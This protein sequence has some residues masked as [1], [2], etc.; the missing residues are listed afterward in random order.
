MIFHCVPFF[1]SPL[2]FTLLYVPLLSS[3]VLN[4][5]GFQCTLRHVY[6]YLSPMKHPILWGKSSVN[7]VCYIA[8]FQGYVFGPNLVKNVLNKGQFNPSLFS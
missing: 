2:Y 4:S 6:L 1:K 3:R 5:V 7:I 8:G